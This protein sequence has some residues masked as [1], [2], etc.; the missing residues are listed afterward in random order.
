[1]V[2]CIVTG[3][4]NCYCL[5][6]E[7]CGRQGNL[8]EKNSYLATASVPAQFELIV[9][10]ECISFWATPEILYYAFIK[11]CHH[12]LSCGRYIQYTVIKVGVM[13]HIVGFVEL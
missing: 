13:T 4:R 3:P 6:L 2:G 7:D 8:E 1:M 5:K 10:Q 12:I 11:P 9:L